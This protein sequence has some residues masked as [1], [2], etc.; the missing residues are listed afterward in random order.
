MCTQSKVAL[1]RFT[2]PRL[3]LLSCEAQTESFETV[4]DSGCDEGCQMTDL[5]QPRRAT[6]WPFA[7]KPVCR[8]WAEPAVYSVAA[9]TAAIPS[10]PLIQMDQVVESST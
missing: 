10:T 9:E 8:T 2:R 5:G 7:S 4:K 3:K 6:F 1:R